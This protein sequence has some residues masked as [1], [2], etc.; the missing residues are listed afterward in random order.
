VIVHRSRGPLWRVILA[1]L[2]WWLAYLFF[3]MPLY[4]AWR[5][6]RWIVA[7]LDRKG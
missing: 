2:G 7:R 3:Y 1:T 6:W 5:L 4:G